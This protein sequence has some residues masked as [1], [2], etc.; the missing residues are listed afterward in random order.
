MGSPSNTK[1]PCAALSSESSAQDAN[2]SPKVENIKLV[3]STYDSP[4]DSGGIPPFSISERVGDL[5]SCPGIALAHCVSQDC[6]IGARIA[7]EFK[8]RFPALK[9]L[10][11]QNPKVRAVP[12][13]DK[14]SLIFN[15]ITKNRYWC[16]MSSDAHH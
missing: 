6:R 3:S 4:T 10:W 5:F 13:M 7:K 16:F 15:L 11:R 14:D 1:A 2:P 8:S 9:A 12:I